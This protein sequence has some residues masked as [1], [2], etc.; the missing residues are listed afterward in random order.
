MLTWIDSALDILST[1]SIN[2]FDSSR[3]NTAPSGTSVAS[4]KRFGK[5]IV[6]YQS[7]GCR[8]TSRLPSCFS[9]FSSGVDDV[10]LLESRG[11]RTMTHRIHL[12]RLPL[13]IKER[14]AHLIRRLPA[15]H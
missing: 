13:P 1:R 14:P 15:N 10:D 8:S 2:D 5:L 4:I 11:H 3:L 9:R 7:L 6:I 12:P